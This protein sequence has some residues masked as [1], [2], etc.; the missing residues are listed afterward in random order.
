MA[1]SLTSSLESIEESIDSDTL[2]GGS[3][4]DFLPGDGNDDSLL[5][6][7]I[8]AEKQTV[9]CGSKD[10]IYSNLSVSAKNVNVEL[11]KTCDGKALVDRVETLKG[12]EVVTKLAIVEKGKSGLISFT[13]PQ[14]GSLDLDCRGTGKEGCIYRI[15]LEPKA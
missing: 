1:S 7:V 15:H 9:N 12:E 2:I 11:I 6:D 10:R 13:V 4:N 8:S 14:N 3:E 5:V